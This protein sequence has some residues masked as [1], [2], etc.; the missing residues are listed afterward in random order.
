MQLFNKIST[1][2]PLQRKCNEVNEDVCSILY[3]VS[4]RSLNK[5]LLTRE[6]DLILLF[7]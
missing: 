3:F 2:S 5:S 1:F 4:F 6:R 7:P